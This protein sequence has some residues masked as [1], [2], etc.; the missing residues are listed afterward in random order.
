MKNVWPHVAGNTQHGLLFVFCGEDGRKKEGVMFASLFRFRRRGGHPGVRQV[1]REKKSHYFRPRLERL[2][3]RTLPT[4]FFT[5]TSTADDGSA[6]TLRWAITQANASTDPSPVID[7][8]IAPAGS[9]VQTISVGSS[10]AFAGVGLP[11]ITHSMSIQGGS[12]PGF[13]GYPPLVALDGTNAGATSGLTI[14]AALCEVDGLAIGNFS[15]D[16]IDIVGAS[17]TYVSEC[18][19]GTVDGSTPAGNSVAGVA[20]EGGASYNHIQASVI[21]GNVDGIDISGAGTTH[22]LV[23]G[24]RIGTD[25]LGYAPLPNTVGVRIFGGAS[26]NLIGNPN[27]AGNIISGNGSAGVEITD[28]NTVYNQVLGNN[29]GTDAH[30]TAALPNAEGVVLFQASDNTIGGIAPGSGNL[31]SGNS[32]FGVIMSATSGNQ[33]QGNRIGTDVSGTMALPNAGGGVVIKSAAAGNTIGGSVTTASTIIESFAILSG[34]VTEAAGLGAGP[35]LPLTQ[36]ILDSGNTSGLTFTPA[37]AGAFGSL[38]APPPGSFAEVVNIPPGDGESGFFEETFDLPSDFSNP[39]LTGTANVDDVGR[40]FLNGHPISPSITSGDPH[41]IT[42]TGNA[43]FSTSDAGFFKP[44]ENVFLLADSNSGGPSAAAFSATVTYSSGIGSAANIISG[45]TGPGVL[46]DGGSSYNGVFTT[47][48]QVQGNSIGVAANGSALGNQTGVLVKGG[49]SGNT[50]GGPGAGNI[51]ANSAHSGVVIMDNA[52]ISNAILDNAIFGN[53]TKDILRLGIDLGGPISNSPGGPHTGP[54][55]LQNYPVLTP[56]F[57]PGTVSGTLN[58]IPN[59]TF[60][61][62]FFANPS[63]S[64][65]E[66][67]DALGSLAVTTDALGNAVFTFT[68]APFPREPFVTATA[69]DAAGDTSEFSAAVTK[70]TVHGALT[71]PRLREG[72]P[73]TGVMGSYIDGQPAAAAAFYSAVIDWGDGSSSPGVVEG[74]D[75]GFDVVG[76]HTYQEEGSYTFFVTI[77][78]VPGLAGLLRGDLTVA[79][80]PLHGIAKSLTGLEETPVGGVVGSFEDADPF[81]FAGEYAATVDW[82]DT[83]T[84]PGTIQ[85]DGAGFDVLAADHTYALEGSYPITV[86][87]TVVDALSGLRT[88]IN[89]TATISDAPLVGNSVTLNVLHHE[90]FAGT[91]ASFTDSDPAAA[92]TDY[93]ATITWD[94]G[95]TTSGT[96]SGTGPFKVSGGHTFHTFAGTHTIQVVITDAGGS[97]VTIGDTV[98]DDPAASSTLVALTDDGH[99]LTFGSAAPRTIS[100]DVAITGLAKGDTLRAIAFDPHGTLYGV[101]FMHWYLIHPTGVAT[102]KTGP[103]LNLFSEGGTLGASFDPVT[104]RLRVIDDLGDNKLIDLATGVPDSFESPT[105]VPGDVNHN[106]GCFLAAI[107]YTNEFSGAG[108]STLY[109]EDVNPSPILVTLGGPNG[110]PSPN[111]GEA[112]TVAALQPISAFTIGGAGNTAYAVGADNISGRTALY[113][114]DLT[115]G[116]ETRVGHFGSDATIVSLAVVPGAAAAARSRV[117]H[118]HR[119]GS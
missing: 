113:T 43:A 82:G 52:S 35:A 6:G 119:H 73:F 44:G 71:S 31:I 80:A 112:H 23:A 84:S 60:H 28:L 16:G 48:N 90:K 8:N 54:N 95:S 7:F 105:F 55:E 98:S 17:G 65:P 18:Y 111:G 58:S 68:Y 13:F 64:S 85:A 39:Q 25:V 33:V 76:S 78:Q 72:V 101:S 103:N 11:S 91:V 109:G 66:G 69:T 94:D 22:N 96:I 34:I 110:D 9:G 12:E 93:Q 79:E 42:E 59:S 89:S 97:Q 3:D 117:A 20:I 56:Y 51:I 77:L 74:V 38:L 86:T 50:I 1:Q 88:V 116:A 26:Y 45:N 46:I 102:L 108:S 107:A 10:S 5:V 118:A 63:G 87:V 114:V 99:L 70:V 40:A 14:N 2:E 115:T 4:T 67:Q 27:L 106:F 83:T 21:S 15:K 81:A 47:G 49:A 57:T 75:G 29:I 53:G 92:A 30:G 19:L 36:T 32:D 41:T 61:L 24:N 62:E 37:L 104:S 100:K